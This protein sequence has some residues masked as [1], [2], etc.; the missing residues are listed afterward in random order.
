[1]SFFFFFF[2]FFFGGHDPAAYE[3]IAFCWN[4]WSMFMFTSLFTV[5]L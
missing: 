1:M 5:L 4:S 2:F 3:D